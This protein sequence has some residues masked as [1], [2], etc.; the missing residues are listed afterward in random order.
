MKIIL[1]IINKEIEKNKLCLNILINKIM[2]KI[3]I[4]NTSDIILD[5]FNW[6]SQIYNKID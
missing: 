2:I 1:I 4:L 5:D 3:L 6:I